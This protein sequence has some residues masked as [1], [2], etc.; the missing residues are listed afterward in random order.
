M[1]FPR[2]LLI[3]TVALFGVIGTSALIKKHKNSPVK[4]SVVVAEVEEEEILLPEPFEL[5]SALPKT[6]VVTVQREV[7]ESSGDSQEGVEV[8]DDFPQCDRIF[9][10]FT[11]GFKKLPIVETITYTSNVSWLKGRPAWLADYANY[12]N[13]SRHFIARS[14]NGKPDYLSQKVIPG[15]KFNV[16]RKDKDI[17]F[18]LLIDLS[19]RKMG[20]YYIDL[21]SNE[22]VLLKTYPVALGRKDE[23]KK[24]GS[25]TPLGKFSLDTKVAIYK[26]GDKGYF[27]GEKVEMVQVFG[28]R[29]IPLKD[30]LEGATGSCK[31]LGI[32]GMPWIKDEESGEYKENSESIGQYV[33]GGSIRLLQA[34]VEEIVA[35]TITR[36]TVIEIVPDFHQAELPGVEKSL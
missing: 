14:L 32:H 25:L 12:Y 18:H 4:E 24:S 33:S 11:T 29:W 21:G 36:P 2:I 22:R 16:F 26:P 10:L 17:Q 15:N 23:I 20:F 9:E 7:E 6:P 28:S 34:D 13:T 30:E 19:S 8:Q 27:Q 35:I 3:G 1:S 31:G 5:V